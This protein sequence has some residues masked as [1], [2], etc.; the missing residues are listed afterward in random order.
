MP[1]KNRCTITKD[2][3][4]IKLHDCVENE[5]K[6]ANAMNDNLGDAGK[7]GQMTDIHAALAKINDKWYGKI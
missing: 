6:L 7:R 1:P 4:L 2:T 3:S 5:W